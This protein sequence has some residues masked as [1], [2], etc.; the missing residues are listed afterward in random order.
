MQ[1]CKPTEAVKTATEADYAEAAAVSTPPRME[2]V[3]RPDRKPAEAAPTAIA[4]TKTEAAA[5]AEERYIGR[6]PER[7]VE[8]AAID[9][10]R[11]PRPR[12]AVGEPATIMIGRPAPRLGA[13]PSPSVGGLIGPV[14]VAIR[15]PALGL[16]GNPHI[17]VVR[18]VLP[19]AVGVQILRSGVVVIRVMPGAGV[20]DHVIAVAVPLIPSVAIGSRRD[21][22]LRGIGVAPHGRHVSSTELGAALRSGDLRFALANDHDGVAIRPHFDAENAIMMRGMDRYVGGIDLGLSFAVFRDREVRDALAQL[23]LNVFLRK[24]RDVG[25]GVRS[26]AKYVGEVELQLGT[27]VVASRNF[28]AGHYRLIQRGC[29]PVSRIAAL[30]GNIAVHQ[31]DSRH[32]LI[33]LRRSFAGWSTGLSLCGLGI[34]G[35]RVHRL[36]VRWASLSHFHWRAGL[37]GGRWA[38]IGRL[39]QSADRECARKR[40]S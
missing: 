23:N 35:L 31:A 18:D 22:V 40:Q 30:C 3:A 29:R 39:R 14:A 27:R 1:W 33:G 32:A 2:I 17:A 12:A 28:V 38:L 19:T 34:G 6:R 15:S 13:N 10:T 8:S 36:S 16:V 21:L 11:P 4:E 24:V 26:Q 9:G 25:L 20:A 5:P 7:A 37:I